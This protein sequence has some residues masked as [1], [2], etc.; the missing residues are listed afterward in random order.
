MYGK[1]EAV[2]YDNAYQANLVVINQFRQS[3]DNRVKEVQQ[4][5][6]Q[7]SINPKILSILD[8]ARLDNPQNDFLSFLL[9][10]ELRKYMQV[11]A[12]VDNYFIRIDQTDS[13]ASSQIKTDTQT[14]FETELSYKYM[15]IARWKEEFVNGYHYQTF[16]PAIEM[17]NDRKILTFVQSLPAG[18]RSNPKGSLFILVDQSKLLDSTE[19]FEKMSSTQVYVLDGQD[20]LLMTS[21]KQPNLDKSLIAKLAAS[22]SGSFEHKT[23]NESFMVSYEV[24]KQTGW[25]YVAFMPKQAF[26][27]PI[28][29]IKNGAIAATAVCMVIGLIIA[30]FMANRNYSPLQNLI[31]IVRT[32]KNAAGTVSKWNEWDTIK[33][34]LEETFA[35]EKF[36]RNQLQ[37]QAPVIQSNFVNRLIRGHVDRDSFS[38]SSLEFVGIQFKWTHYA[39]L[40]IDVD[41]CNDFIKDDSERQWAHVRFII[42]NILQE[43]L[44]DKQM[45]SFSVDFERDQIGVLVNHDQEPRLWKENITD[46]LA[47]LTE[48]LDKRFSIFITV[49][50][51]DIGSEAALIGSCY[52]QAQ[53]ALDYKSI[54]GHRSILFFGDLI[55]AQKTY[56]YPVEMEGQVINFVKNADYVQVKK[57][58]E[59]IYAMNFNS[60][61][62]APEFG[63]WLMY[64]IVS[65]LLKCLQVL[66]LQYRDVFPEEEEPDTR[67]AL[68]VTIREMFEEIMNMY[69]AFCQYLKNERSDH[70]NELKNS[71]LAY[72]QDHVYDGML[73]LVSIADHFRFSPQYVSKFF[74]THTGQTLSDYIAKIRVD[75]AK[76]LLKE[77]DLTIM[78][79]SQKLGYSTDIGLLRIFKKHEG[80]TPG[81]YRVVSKE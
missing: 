6:T 68:C 36:L 35:E 28:Q 77:T 64:N 1:M 2:I 13:I 24:S 40:L 7:I 60:G 70:N 75:E 72:I 61:A 16:F 26:I 15:S 67:L 44:T 65:T 30:H 37:K 76:K 59:Q 5:A 41:D 42:S 19:M 11:S 46:A 54:K 47:A 63:K 17:N 79:I 53:R 80:I 12:I 3:I 50:V 20:R 49:A 8:E 38:E 22:S 14:F 29:K 48:I 39:V 18:E 27:M 32:R 57:L 9:T 23:A 31:N 71:M 81:R 52:T 74:K 62:I 66:N 25:K 69:A 51:S 34:S 73:G 33:Q 21:E 78:E 43:M 56:F 45:Q 58:L 10:A 4:F 55:D